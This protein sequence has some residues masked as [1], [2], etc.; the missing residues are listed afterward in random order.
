MLVNDVARGAALR[1]WAASFPRPS[2]I[3]VV[4][5][6]YA[7]R[8]VELGRTA[9]GFAMFNLPRPL[10]RL[11]PPD[12][13]YATPPSEDLAGRVEAL[14]VGSVP[15]HRGDRRGFD[16]TTWIPLR[17]M[18]PAADVPVLEIT[19]PY[20]REAEQLAFGKRLSPLRAEGVPLPRERREDAQ[21][22]VRRPRAVR[23]RRC[24][25]GRATSTPGP[26]ARS[27]RATSARARRLPA[28]ASTRRRPRPSGRRRSLPRAP[29]RALGFAIGS[30]TADPARAHFRS[31]ASSRRSRSAASKSPN[32]GRKSGRSCRSPR[33]QCRPS[34]R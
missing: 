26:R 34:A 9:R 7:S 20:A 27:R 17:H 5:P 16:H 28:Q 29:R 33:R 18:F 22:R 12:A 11:L 31:P 1:A 30:G 25:R 23:R 6:H 32:S 15:V 4:T 3:L 13:E 2:G 24:R 21:P 19:Y 8:A 10:K 14:L